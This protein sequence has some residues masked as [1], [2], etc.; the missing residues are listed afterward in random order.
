MDYFPYGLHIGIIFSLELC[1]ERDLSEELWKLFLKL[2]M[3]TAPGKACRNCIL[4][5]IG[6]TMKSW[7]QRE[8]SPER[9]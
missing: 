4:G 1:K 2:D 7:E 6:N 5:R 8:M 9:V 3:E